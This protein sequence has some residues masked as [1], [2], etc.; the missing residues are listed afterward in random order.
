MVISGSQAL[1]Q[2]RVP[3]AEL[4]PKTE[5]SLQISGL[6]RQPLCHRRPRSSSEWVENFIVSKTSV[7]SVRYFGWEVYGFS[8]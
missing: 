8:W 2:A 1:R 5:G 7:I 6:T 4:E 3:V